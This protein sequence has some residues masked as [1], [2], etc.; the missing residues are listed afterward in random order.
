M[1]V[2]RIH[3]F[4]LLALGI[5]CRLEPPCGERGPRN[6]L[7]ARNYIERVFEWRRHA[8]ILAHTARAT[9]GMAATAVKTW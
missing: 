9:T 3:P 8:G 5:G 2:V 4:P 1:T 6:C 7:R